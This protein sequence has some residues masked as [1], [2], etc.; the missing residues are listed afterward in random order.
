MI[1]DQDMHRKI[2]HTIMALKISKCLNNT[3]NN[4]K[5]DNKD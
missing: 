3:L 1:A 2:K 5:N 4:N